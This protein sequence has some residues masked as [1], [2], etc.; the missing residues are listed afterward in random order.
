M[1]ALGGALQYTGGSDDP[2]NLPRLIFERVIFD[3]N[4]AAAAG[5]AVYIDGRA[6]M[7]V[8]AGAE[9]AT[10]PRATPDGRTVAVSRSAQL[11]FQM[12]RIPKKKKTSF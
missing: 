3:H 6:G 11:K 7:P 2:S 5:A 4:V 1:G 9:G 10:N 12:W 8:G